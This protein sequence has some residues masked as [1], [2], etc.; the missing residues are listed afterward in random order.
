MARRDRG[1]RSGC[2]SG[3]EA[4]ASRWTKSDAQRAL[5]SWRASGLSLSAWCRQEGLGYERVRRWR[6]QLGGRPAQPPKT[7][8]LPVQVLEAGPA[9]APG[10]ELALPRG[11]RLHVPSAFDEASLARLLQVVE[12]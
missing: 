6:S 5:A 3:G 10:F 11:L 12:R 4:T 9:E 8:F 1:S 7:A 2:V